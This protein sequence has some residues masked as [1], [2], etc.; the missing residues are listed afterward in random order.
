MKTNKECPSCGANNDFILTNCVFCSTPLPEIKLDS[1]DN[2]TLILN[3]GEWVG[4]SR[5]HD[6][7]IHE[8][9]PDANMFTGRGVKSIK[10]NNADMVA[11]AEKYLAL[12]QVR[13]ISNPNLLAIHNSLRKQLEQNKQ[14]A[15]END[16]MTKAM[17][18]ANNG[19]KKI[20]LFFLIFFILVIIG[21]ILM[22]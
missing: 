6:Y 5:Q 12:I 16:P 2:E 13:S 14:I 20:G 11:N 15:L 4:K 8:A 22:K 17:A 9:G 19:I 7:V 21:M 18:H 3:A 10:I 1:I